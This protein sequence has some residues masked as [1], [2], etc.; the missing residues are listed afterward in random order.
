MKESLLWM[1]KHPLITACLLS[2]FILAMLTAYGIRRYMLF[3]ETTSA[4]IA[5]ICWHPDARHIFSSHIDGSLEVAS[6]GDDGTLTG[7]T[8]R[9]R[10][11]GRWDI[12]QEMV[13]ALSCSA[14]GSMLC[15]HTDRT[16]RIWNAHDGTEIVHQLSKFSYDQKFVWNGTK[17]EILV[18][19]TK[20]KQVELWN[21]KDGTLISSKHLTTHPAI[22]SYFESRWNRDGSTLFL[23]SRGTSSTPKNSFVV[24][25]YGVSEGE[26]IST[27]IRPLK[28]YRHCL[29]PMGTRI[30]FVTENPSPGV[31]MN[32]E[33]I[34]L[35][36][37]AIDHTIAV[38]ST[39]IDPVASPDSYLQS[40]TMCAW[41]SDGKRIGVLVY[42]N[43]K[44]FHCTW[45][46]AVNGNLIS[47]C[48]L[49][50]NDPKYYR[51]LVE[52]PIRLPLID[53]LISYPMVWSP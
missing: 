21:A 23:G 32:M 25:I 19:D 43:L 36:T 35:K 48:K 27:L 17:H 8:L 33:I 11:G 51:M 37:G 22:E 24:Q 5:C 47:C 50:F 16:L 49:D 38:P 53:S 30:V 6:I 41:S 31:L 4:P 14:D 12:S 29:N 2:F 15:G 28:S 7:K 42:H 34:D 45:C 39:L 26:I 1:Q 46:D 52:T 44:G 3:M 40:N 10:P 9:E 13:L 20:S 18:F